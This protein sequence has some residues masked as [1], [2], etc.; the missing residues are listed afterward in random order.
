M[1]EEMKYCCEDSKDIEG[2]GTILDKLTEAAGYT[3][4]NSIEG[5]ECEENLKR[6]EIRESIHLNPE[7]DT[8]A[9]EV[10][11]YGEIND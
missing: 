7:I 11:G 2:N 3:V 1:S 9:A 8:T 4:Y 6:K 5:C 10:D